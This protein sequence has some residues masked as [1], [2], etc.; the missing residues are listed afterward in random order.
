MADP[1]RI[2]NMFMVSKQ[3]VFINST[4]CIL[5]FPPCLMKSLISVTFTHKLNCP[6]I[7]EKNQLYHLM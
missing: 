7:H 6:G 2:M 3:M 1:S 5:A 4:E